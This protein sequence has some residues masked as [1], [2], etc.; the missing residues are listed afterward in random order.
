MAFT[1]CSHTYTLFWLMK[2]Y[3]IIEM[4]QWSFHVFMCAF[5]PEIYWFFYKVSSLFSY[6]LYYPYF[7]IF[8]SMKIGIQTNYSSY[9]WIAKRIPDRPQAHLKIKIQTVKTFNLTEVI[10]NW[11]TYPPN[12]PP[13]SCLQMTSF[14]W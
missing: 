9:Q 13:I 7:G 8:L 10:I 11:K 1:M 12:M 5:H 4:F 6:F 2:T 14:E 3:V